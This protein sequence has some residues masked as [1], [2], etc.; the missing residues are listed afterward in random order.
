MKADGEK[1]YKIKFNEPK[2]SM[3][4]DI[5]LMVGE[6]FSTASPLYSKQSRDQPNNYSWDPNAARRQEILLELKEG[7]I[8]F[9]NAPGAKQTVVCQGSVIMTKTRETI[10]TIKLKLLDRYDKTAPAD[11]AVKALRR[12]ITIVR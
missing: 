10:N 7:L 3:R 6:F 5:F 8:V 12:T 11:V 2:M 4:M 1:I 9:E